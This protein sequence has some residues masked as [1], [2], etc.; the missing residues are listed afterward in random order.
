MRIHLVSVGQKLDRW[1][2]DAYQEYAKRLPSECALNLIEIPAGKRGKNT[3]IQRVVAQEGRKALAAVPQNSFLIALEVL[4]KSWDTPALARE[5]DQW[6]AGGQDVALL[7]GGPEG[8]SEECKLA[9][10][11][12]WSLSPLTLPH[13][14]VRVIVAEQLYRAWSILSNH[15]YHR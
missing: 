15:P 4:G 9:A 10:K 6:R 14:L 2:N 7:I 13:P 5:L 11:K 1:V 8:L 12:H 3:D